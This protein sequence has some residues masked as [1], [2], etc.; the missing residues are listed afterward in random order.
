M[1]RNQTYPF[2]KVLSGVIF[3]LFNNDYKIIA[4]LYLTLILIFFQIRSHCVSHQG[5]NSV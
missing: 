4:F 1:H 3:L 5:S 2:P